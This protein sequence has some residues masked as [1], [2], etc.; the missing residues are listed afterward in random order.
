[1][2]D[3]PRKL[4]AWSA[5]VSLAAISLAALASPFLGSS[6]E[7]HATLYLNVDQRAKQIYPVSLWAV[8]G[9][10]SNRTDQGM[11]WVTPGE[12]TFSFKMH[13]VNSADAP[14]MERDSGGQR[15]QPHDLKVTLEAG[16]V[17]Y[18]GGKLGASQTWTPVVW[19]T[20][21]QPN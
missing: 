3:M 8:D 10:L 20:E 13:A 21:D 7:P 18:I 17:Y 11:L 15:D 2:K 4:F 6:K 12:Y 9:K 14:G 5:A 19:K 16:K 1:M